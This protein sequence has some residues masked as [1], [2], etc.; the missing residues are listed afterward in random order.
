VFV[1]SGVGAD[2]IDSYLPHADGF[3]IG[4]SFKRGGDARQPVDPA[5]VRELM[6]RLR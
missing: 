4:S 2:T 1:G 3:I 5:R 6:S